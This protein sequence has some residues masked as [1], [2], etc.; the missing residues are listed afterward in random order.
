[1]INKYVFALAVALVLTALPQTA[2]AQVIVDVILL[3]G[4]N[5]DDDGEGGGASNSMTGNEWQFLVAYPGEYY[6]C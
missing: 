6:C 2:Q 5:G 3:T 4:G 1:M